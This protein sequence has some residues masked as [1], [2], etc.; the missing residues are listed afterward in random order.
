MSQLRL[1]H[2]ERFSC[3]AQKRGVQMPQ[4]MPTYSRNVCSV[5]S[6]VDNPPK[7]IVPTQR[8]SPPGWE[9]KIIG[10]A[11]FDSLSVC[12]QCSQHDASQRKIPHAVTCLLQ[13]TAAYVAVLRL[14]AAFT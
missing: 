3:F 14:L 2:L 13:E 1:R 10:A 11:L 8:R 7:Q 5:A 4:A 12:Q 6:R 9:E